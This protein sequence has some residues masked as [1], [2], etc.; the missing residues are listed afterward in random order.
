MCCVAESAA[1]QDSHREGVVWCRVREQKESSGSPTGGAGERP[2]D[3]RELQGRGHLRAA[4]PPPP[5]LS[6]E[7]NGQSTTYFSFS[8]ASLVPACSGIVGNI[9]RDIGQI[10]Q[11]ISMLF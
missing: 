5:A 9:L 8:S 10:W 11:A 6:R 7:D 4:A 2:G 1:R 3:G